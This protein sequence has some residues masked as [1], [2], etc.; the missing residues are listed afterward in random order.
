MACTYNSPRFSSKYEQYTA[1][2][3]GLHNIF[4]I[5]DASR[6]TALEPSSKS[7]KNIGT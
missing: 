4:V 6:F 2:P 7:G 3:Y 1:E 5:V